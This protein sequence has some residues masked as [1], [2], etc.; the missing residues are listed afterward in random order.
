MET[1]RTAPPSAAHLFG[2]YLPLAEQ[3]AGMLAD[4][5]VQRGLLGPREAERIWERHLLNCAVVAELLPPDAGVLDLGT[6]AGLPGIVLALVRPDVRV[7]LVEPMLRRVEFLVECVQALGLDTVTVRRARAE[8]LVGGVEVDVVTV[9]A[10]APLRR[11]LPL[12]MPLLTP[13]GRLLAMKGRQAAAELAAASSLVRRVGG[14][15]GRVLT[16]GAGVIDPP[17]T[18][19]EVRRLGGPPPSDGSP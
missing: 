16:C 5:A 17:T 3:Y 4:V 8:E 10:V 9:R 6:G 1:G 19:V 11:L 14:R 13:G 12:A 15:R 18:V 7:M 2:P